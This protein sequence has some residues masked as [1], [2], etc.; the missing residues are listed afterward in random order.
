MSG[1]PHAASISVRETLELLDGPFAE[2]ASGIAEDRYALW[3]GSGISLGKIPGLKVLIRNALEHLQG[4]VAVV[5]ANCRFR[6][7]IAEILST[8]AGLS[9]AECG[10]IDVHQPVASW[11][12]IDAIIQRLASNYARFLEIGVAGEPDDYILWTGADLPNAFADPASEPDTE[13]LCIG[14]LI[15]E[16]I[17]SR[18][19]SANWDGLIEKAVDELSPRANALVVCVTGTDLRQPQQQAFLYKF[20]GCAVRARDDEANFRARI[21]AR[22]SQINAWRDDQENAAMVARLVD[23]AVS[24][25]TLMIGL[26]AQDSNIQTVFT[27]AE[28]QMGWPWPSHP[29]AYAFSEDRLGVDQRAL[30]RNVYRSSYSPA[31]RDA[32]YQ[33]ALIR[34]Y[35]KPLLT[36]LVLHALCAKLCRLVE[37]APGGLGTPDSS[38]IKEGLKHLRNAVGSHPDA[39][40]VAFIRMIVARA[41]RLMAL[42]HTG[43]ATAPDLPYLPITSRPVQAMATDPMIATAGLRELAVG[44]SLLGLGHRDGSWAVQPAPPAREQGALRIV[45]ATN[46]L[47]LVFAS[48]AQAA[49]RLGANGHIGPDDD[50]IV[51]HSQ[52]VF[53]T[54]PRS[55]RATRG[56]LGRPGRRDVSVTE[57]LDS[58]ANA[59]ELL[60]GFRKAAGI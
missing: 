17:A 41:S 42:Y 30:L 58:A 45:T 10:T 54:M 11:P 51:M 20:H 47:K 37:L 13:H 9:P 34:A 44:L 55:P 57:L 36:A 7:T 22:L 25:E 3:L 33:S 24:H 27:A 50:V 40:A 49:I 31:N 28:N 32:I 14:L 1:T 59:N 18:I 60:D 48:T 19:A 39:G 46:N 6:A 26:S 29:P 8:A 21:I 53:P 56:R 15:L 4:K 12:N 43:D 16:G 2:M 38:A 35:A 5:D 52:Q 23:L